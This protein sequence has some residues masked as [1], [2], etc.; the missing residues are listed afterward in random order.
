[1]RRVP[2]NFMR[3]VKGLLNRTVDVIGA[4]TSGSMG[5]VTQTDKDIVVKELR[6][7]FQPQSAWEQD[8]VLG[9][10]TD[11]TQMFFCKTL[12]NSG[13][14]LNIHKGYMLR[15]QLYEGKSREWEVTDDPENYDDIYLAVPLRPVRL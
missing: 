8:T 7:C 6:G 2:V 5:G 13:I 12:D 15:E 3:A 10:Y 14:K 1:M 11:A 9:K 4:R